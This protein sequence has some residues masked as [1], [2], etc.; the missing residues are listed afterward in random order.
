MCMAVKTQ[1]FCLHHVVGDAALIKNVRHEPTLLWRAF[2][3]PGMASQLI[4][5]SPSNLIFTS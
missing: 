4:L 3:K 5:K 1:S 2:F